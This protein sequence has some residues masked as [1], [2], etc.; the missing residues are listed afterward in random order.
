ML[1]NDEEFEAKR[2]VD[3]TVATF[4]NNES[5]QEIYDDEKNSVTTYCLQ[6][7]ASDYKS[8]NMEQFTDNRHNVK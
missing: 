7:Q 8:P 1:D 5:T 4:L 6:I 2:M 3:N